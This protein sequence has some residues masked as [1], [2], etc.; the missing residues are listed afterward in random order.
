MFSFKSKLSNK[1][2]IGAIMKM[3]ADYIIEWVAWHKL[4]G[5]DLI[6]ADNCTQGAQTKL[7]QDLSA[8]GYLHYVDARMHPTRPQLPAYHKIF[9]AAVKLRY[10]YFGFMDTD[11]FFEPLQG[12]AFAGATLITTLLERADTWAV[13]F[14]WCLFG[15][16]L[17]E[18]AKSGFVVDR[19]TMR[20]QSEAKGNRYVKSFARINRIFLGRWWRP[21]QIFDNPHFFRVS[22]KHYWLDG[23]VGARQIL[24]D[25]NH[26]WQLARIRHY[27][28]KSHEEFKLKRGKG[29]VFY[30][31]NPDEV[32]YLKD[33]DLND[34]ADPMKAESI[35]RLSEKVSE[36]LSSLEKSKPNT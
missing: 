36:I 30:E 9:W 17:N 24:D 11:E 25:E 14:R 28:I 5:F 8:R 23:K 2:V 19:F 12:D 31:I 15:S 29:N 34:V 32:Q 20:G 22:R 16:T 1:P 13:S 10:R 7:L 33:F 35:I 27:A 26:P 18:H 6:V 21:L 4:Q 3:E